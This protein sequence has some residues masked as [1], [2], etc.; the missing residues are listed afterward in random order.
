MKMRRSKNAYMWK[1]DIITHSLIIASPHIRL[2]AST[3]LRM[4][5][6]T[7]YHTREVKHH[8]KVYVF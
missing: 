6:F 2:N 5:A 1:N 7:H 3:H 4:N 8:E